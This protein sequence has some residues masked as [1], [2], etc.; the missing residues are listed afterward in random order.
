VEA[1]ETGSAIAL[2]ILITL[3]AT[4]ALVARVLAA[5]L[6]A[7]L[8]IALA[9]VGARLRATRIALAGLRRLSGLSLHGLPGALA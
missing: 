5:A 1:E 3:F 2:G 4:R 9:L 7:T 8:T 6:I